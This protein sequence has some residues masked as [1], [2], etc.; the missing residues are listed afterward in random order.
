MTDLFLDR[1]LSFEKEAAEVTLP[2]DPNQWSTEILQELYKQVPYISDFEPNINLLSVDGER[3]VGLGWIEVSSKTE[4]APAAPETQ[5]QAAGIRKARI[6]VIISEKKL[7]SLDLVLTDD[8]K[9]LPLTE[10]RLR[11]AM[12]R[13]QMFDIASKTPGDMSIISQLYPPFRQNYG[14]GGGTVIGADKTA[15][16]LS[17]NARSK[18]KEEHF[19]IPS[20][21]KYPIHDENH[22]RIA[23][24]FARMHGSP[25]E[26]SQ[27]FAAVAKKYPHIASNS[28][29]STVRDKV[30][31][32]SLL[33]AILPTVNS[34]DYE[35]FASVCTQPDVAAGYMANAPALKSSLDTL[36]QYIHNDYTKTAERLPA[37]I[38]PDV[39]QIAKT[40]DGYLV[41]RA[42]AKM[43]HPVGGYMHRGE[44][45]RT[46]GE[47][48]ALAVDTSG[49]MTIAQG[50]EVDS[51][52]PEGPKAEIIH[53]FGLYKVRTKDGD[54]L[55]GY[56]FP[57][58]LDVDGH[59]LP[60]ALF[61]NGS[62]AALQG[63]I[64]GMKAGEGAPLM[65]SRPI[66]KG[67]FYKVLANGKAQATIPLDIHAAM[68]DRGEVAL[69]ATSFH[70]QQI[71]IKVQPV[72]QT[73][74]LVGDTMV[75]PAEFKWLSLDRCQNV[76]LEGEADAVE[77][78]TAAQSHS[79][80]VEIRSGGPDSFSFSG[81]AVDKL[82]HEERSFLDRD[83]AMF[84]LGGLGVEPSY[85][86]TKIAQAWQQ[87]EPIRVK[88]ARRITTVRE[89]AD[90]GKE[91]AAAYVNAVPALKK[92]LFKEAAVIADPTA[93]DTVLSLGFLNPE[94]IL[95]FVEY[96]P[97]IDDAQAK[98][99]E[100][101]LASRLGIREIPTS[102]LE[103]SIKSTEEVI[104]GLKVLAFRKQ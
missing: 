52:M 89:F 26:K 90:A 50:A 14:M 80:Y 75:V 58:L 67:C 61:T 4:A 100:L 21:R 17:E 24:G 65:E 83:G 73:V 29:I 33:T 103:R 28:S 35:K 48:I 36:D 40:I 10:S 44:L 22:A 97:R 94:N 5:L 98:M 102:A 72:I 87:Q 7:Q 42:S 79:S 71:K 57:N 96:L 41:K 84:L 30:S 47:K 88:I 85:G 69:M 43:W 49:S 78:K 104:N 51:D 13:P 45:V 82:A 11:Q 2:D 39:M 63:E 23:L 76:V 93:V 64:V 101:L 15:A 56:V 19:A 55:I 86:V 91:K 46:F 54:D 68:S 31:S 38:R 81:P 34:A 6:P 92:V 12:F 27:V 1:P 53:D 16:P 66:G 70:G 77:A 3:G 95:T 18:I 74:E 32:V 62:A 9:V 37:M 8:S 59:S 60:L 99:C 25:E 20:L